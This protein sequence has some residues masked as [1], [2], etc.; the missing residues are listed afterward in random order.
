MSTVIIC[1]VCGETAA[2]CTCLRFHEKRR[3][4]A[5]ASAPT[6]SAEP[7][8]KQLEN[9]VQEI[10][11]LSKSASEKDIEKTLVH[12]RPIIWELCSRLA[13]AEKA[14]DE[15][16]LCLIAEQPKSAKQKCDEA[17]E[18]LRRKNG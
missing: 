15:A 12:H 9:Y 14:L 10:E 18:T 7:A 1:G 11:R 4:P 2:E 3:I 16:R 5:V 17:L 8:P 13:V 6:P